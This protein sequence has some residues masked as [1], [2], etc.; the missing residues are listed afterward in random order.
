M[1]M[2]KQSDVLEGG[3]FSLEHQES[4]LEEAT[5]ELRPEGLGVSY[6]KN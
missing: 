6:D 4:L 3:C 5:F 1:E 2:Q